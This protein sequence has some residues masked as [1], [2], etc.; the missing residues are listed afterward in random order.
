MES[1][2]RVVIER[3]AI[4][5]RKLE[6]M[7]MVMRFAIVIPA[8]V[9]LRVLI[10]MVMMVMIMMIVSMGF[11]ASHAGQMNVFAQ[12]GHC[13]PCVNAEGENQLVKDCHVLR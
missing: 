9:G 4:C 7:M 5:D 6:A 1:G 12:G 10:V 13:H 2:D 11:G 8:V 3:R